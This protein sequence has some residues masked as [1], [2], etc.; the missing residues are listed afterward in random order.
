MRGAC[1]A[2]WTHCGGGSG[3]GAGA[4]GVGGAVAPP[5]LSPR[6]KLSFG[7]SLWG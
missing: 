6:E 4:E 2:G 7:C 1:L 5:Y 3:V